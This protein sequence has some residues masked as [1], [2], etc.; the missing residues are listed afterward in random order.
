[1]AAL[2][3]GAVPAFRKGRG[4]GKRYLGAAALVVGSVVAL[5]AAGG[6]SEPGLL[7]ILLSPLAGPFLAALLSAWAIRRG[8]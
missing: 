7:V 3:G 4:A 1:M 8:A 2:A 6:P 5:A